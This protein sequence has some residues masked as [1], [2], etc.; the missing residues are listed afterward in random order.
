[1]ADNKGFEDTIQSMLAQLP[2]H[3]QAFRDEIEVFSRQVMKN[4]L[5]DMGGVSYEAFKAQQSLLLRKS[6]EL[7]ALEKKV[8]ALEKTLKSK[9]KGDSV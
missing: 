3:L 8:A 9:I 5:S 1:M 6:E 7:A 2:Q 4:V